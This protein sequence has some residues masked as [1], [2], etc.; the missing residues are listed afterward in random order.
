MGSALLVIGI[1]Q[2][3]RFY[4]LRKNTAYREKFETAVSDERYH[5]IRSK[6]W[7]WAGYLFVLAGAVS[8]IVFRIMGE[9]LLSLAASGSVCFV[10]V[11]Y[12][13][14][15]LEIGRAHV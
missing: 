7:A 1:L 3:L 9:E 11:A 8:S 14:S 4:R 12:W 2:V 15:Y 13:V 5:F 10:L 6:A